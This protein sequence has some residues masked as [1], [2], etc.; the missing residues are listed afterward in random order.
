ML[1]FGIP[2][3]QQLIISFFI[4]ST[5]ESSDFNL[6]KI[7]IWVLKFLILIL[8]AVVLYWLWS[9][10]T[11]LQNKVPKDLELNLSLFK[12]FFFIP[13]IYFCLFTFASILDAI[14]ITDQ[15]SLRHKADI[16]LTYGLS[17]VMNRFRFLILFSILYCLFFIIKTI[18]TIENGKSEKIISLIPDILLFCI[19][20][21]GIWFLQPRINRIANTDDDFLGFVDERPK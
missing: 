4:F 18:R 11:G 13:V 21:I 15:L 9:V 12:I 10:A 6:L 7:Y 8:T 17:L 19:Y 14:N 3:V 2:L 20:P 1:T 16:T 5:F